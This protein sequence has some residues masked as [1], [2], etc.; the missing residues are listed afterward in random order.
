[1][2]TRSFLVAILVSPLLISASFA[3]QAIKPLSL[4]GKWRVSAKHPSGAMI[5][6]TVQLTTDLKFTTTSTV[7]EKPFLIASGTWAL[8][9][10]KLEWRY[11]QSSQPSI[12]PGFVDVDEVLSVNETELTLTSKLSGKTHT[13]QRAQ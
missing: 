10:T 8:T 2:K 12:P 1:M 5:T 13:Y 7:N 4:L 6:T 9:G 11:E 3:Q